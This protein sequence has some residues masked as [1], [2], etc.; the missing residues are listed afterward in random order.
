MFVTF[1]RHQVQVPEALNP[2]PGGA[3][4]RSL[5]WSTY[6]AWFVLSWR[7][8]G[9]R[10]VTSLLCWDRDVA[11]AIEASSA[12]V[13]SL[14]CVVPPRNDHDDAWHSVSIREVWRAVD[15]RDGSANS[16][17]FVAENGEERAGVFCSRVAGF[18]RT[19]LVARVGRAS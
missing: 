10:H 12:E 11:D 2:Y 8:T 6:C 9:A 7:P 15:P 5:E 19:R 14:L 13:S 3:H 4:W 18:T 1:P 16:I 17:L